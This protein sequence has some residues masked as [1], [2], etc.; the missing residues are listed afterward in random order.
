MATQAASNVNITGGTIASTQINNNPIVGGTINN[1]AIGGTTAA[2]G[3]FTNL[4]ATSGTMSGPLTLAADPTLSLG[5][6]TK[7]YVDNKASAALPLMDGAA[8]AGAAATF[9]RGDHVHPTDTSRAPL[10]SP[11]FT[12]LVTTTGSV[13]LG[14]PGIVYANYNASNTFGFSLGA[15]NSA[16]LAQ[17]N[18]A[19]AFGYVMTSS[20]TASGYI[21]LYQ[22]IMNNAGNTISASYSG[23]A[24]TWACT[25][26][27]RRLK[28][29]LKPANLDA[30]DALGKLKVYDCDMRAP[31]DAALV[32]HWDCAL[33]ADEVEGVIPR[34]YMAPSTSGE[35]ESFASLNLL[36]LVATLVKAVQ[37]LTARVATLEAK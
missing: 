13:S 1:T 12:G 4:S 33:I 26:S 19:N 16:L 22:I 20:L 17:V 18:G 21:G 34:A 14:G 27:D 11:S 3:N 29:N 35:G 8:T 10:A 24:A 5:A 37:Q 30:L 9:T 36:P 31:L 2:S 32:E 15:G 6:S 23:G 7:Q 25:L 28:S